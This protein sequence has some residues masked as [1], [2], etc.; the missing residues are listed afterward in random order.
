MCYDER[1]DNELVFISCYLSDILVSELM[2][3]VQIFSSF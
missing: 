2:V 3:V 1:Y